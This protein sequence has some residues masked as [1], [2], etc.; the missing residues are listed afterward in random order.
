MKEEERELTAK[1]PERYLIRI[2]KDLLKIFNA[3]KETSS[4]KTFWLWR[5]RS[6]FKRLFL[7]YRSAE[8]CHIQAQVVLLIGCS[9]KIL[10]IVVH[11]YFSTLADQQIFKPG[12]FFFWGGGVGVWFS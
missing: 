9:L 1:S 4:W 8:T 10:L 11:N 2:S 12:G 3:E 7:E 6:A 5:L